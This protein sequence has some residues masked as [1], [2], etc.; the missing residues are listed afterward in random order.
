MIK[1]LK[2]SRRLKILRNSKLE[3]IKD[4]DQNLIDGE[5]FMYSHEDIIMPIIMSCWVSTPEAIEFRS[6]LRFKQH[7]ITLSKKQSVISKITK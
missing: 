1:K 6:K 2:A 4:T 7:D 5:K 3:K